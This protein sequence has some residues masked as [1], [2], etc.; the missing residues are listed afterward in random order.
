MA[1]VDSDYRFI[2]ADI[3]G[4]GRISDGGIFQNSLIWQKIDSNSINLP[5]DTPLPG[6]EKKYA[7]R[8]SW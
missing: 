1:L 2:F 7:L 8:V 6:R 3:G 5:T 4:Q